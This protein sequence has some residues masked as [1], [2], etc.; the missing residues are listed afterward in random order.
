LDSPAIPHVEVIVNSDNR[1]SITLLD[2]DRKPI[3]PGEHVLTVTAGQRSSAKK[4]QLEKQGDKFISEP[5]PKGAPY[6]M[7][8]QIKGTG[9]AKA[10]TARLNYDPTPANSGKPAYL[11]DSVN[12]G[13]GPN[14]EVPEALA[15]HWAEIDSHHSELKENFGKKAYEPLDEVTQALVALLEAL[16]MKSQEKKDAVAQEVKKLVS[17]IEAIARANAARDLPKA[18]E[19]LQTVGTGLATLK[20]L[21]PS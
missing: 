15:E 5:V 17:E 16:P 7:V 2:A 13:S 10:L 8:I 1:A 19:A 14:I 6:T 11:D 4:L 18:S 3:T 9:G 20:K 12:E 21:I